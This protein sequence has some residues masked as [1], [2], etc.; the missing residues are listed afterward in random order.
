M[1]HTLKYLHFFVLYFGI[2]LRKSKQSVS[3]NKYLKLASLTWKQDLVRE[4]YSPEVAAQISTD[5]LIWPHVTHGRYLIK[6]AYQ[7]LHALEVR[8]Q[9]MDSHQSFMALRWRNLRS[10][11]LSLNMCFCVEVLARV[12]GH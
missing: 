2:S 8:D 7:L 4:L 1:F 6:I 12:H 9:V 10:L 3:V 11:K 5:T